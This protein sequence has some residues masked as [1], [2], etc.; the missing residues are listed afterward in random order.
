MMDVL[1]HRWI[2]FQ[3]TSRGELLIEFF[4]VIFTSF[5]LVSTSSRQS[6]ALPSCKSVITLLMCMGGDLCKQTKTIYYQYD[7][8]PI[9]GRVNTA[10]PGNPFPFLSYKVWCLVSNITGSHNSA[11]WILMTFFPGAQYWVH[12]LSEFRVNPFCKR[13][14]VRSLSFT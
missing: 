11:F 5:L 12:Y 1:L 13:L 4:K 6:S 10:D 7:I 14:L 8:Q 9:K 2:S 3:G